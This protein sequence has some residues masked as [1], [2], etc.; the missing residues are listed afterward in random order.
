MSIFYKIAYM[1]GLTP[2]EEMARLPISR[3]ITSL[4]D[5][6]QQ[7]RQPPFGSALDLGCGS[8]NWSIEL[9]R[10][11]WRVTGLDIVSKALRNARRHSGEAGVD[12]RFVQGDMTDFG[13][14]EVGFGF[15]LLI[16]F[17]AIHGLNP[18]Q[19]K[20]VGRAV[21]SVAA[22]GATMLLLAWLPGKRGPLPRGMS[23]EEILEALPGWEMIGEDIADVSGAPGFIRKARPCF[24]RLQRQ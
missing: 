5:R 17:G 9:A 6:E 13:P 3:Q 12:V 22:T 14:D 2:W 11:G 24:Y 10:R 18:E 23:R 16:D 20:A 7:A 21:N 8:G 19:R 15:E 1:I 4:L